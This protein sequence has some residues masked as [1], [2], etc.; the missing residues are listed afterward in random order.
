MKL[1]ANVK[2]RE[3]ALNFAKEILTKDLKQNL[4]DFKI[5]V[6]KIKYCTFKII[7]KRKV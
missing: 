7:I 5:I 6:T 3:R 2:T 1:I 4:S